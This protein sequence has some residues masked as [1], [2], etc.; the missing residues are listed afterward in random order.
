M[1]NLVWSSV[2]DNNHSEVHEYCSGWSAIELLGLTQ[3]L[4]TE[5]T[6]STRP[7]Q[8]WREP[9]SQKTPLVAGSWPLPALAEVV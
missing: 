1:Q 7:C 2:W 9:L 4:E 5:A 6:K 8:S 3:Q